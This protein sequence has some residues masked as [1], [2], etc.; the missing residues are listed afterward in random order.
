MVQTA[1][2]PLRMPA[3]ARKKQLL[4]IA[5]QVFA[6]DGYHETSMNALAAE[7]GVTKPVLYQHFASKHLLVDEILD[8]LGN[9]LLE[10]ISSSVSKANTSRER[11]QLG[12]QAIFRFFD[13]EPS[14]FAVFFGQ[15]LGAD[16][17]F[18]NAGEKIELKITETIARI[19]DTNIPN[20]ALTMASGV[21]G[22][23]KGMVTFWM[24]T[25]R[26]DS[27]DKMAELATNLVWEGLE[28]LTY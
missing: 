25:G 12:F 7:A 17:Q 15:K 3:A 6:R 13:E 21:N 14:A 22:L 9:D 5:L 20:D 24:S 8:G 23:A 2:A 11:V 19:I 16:P 28:N 4:D 10:A 27:P 1:M 26:V 18:H